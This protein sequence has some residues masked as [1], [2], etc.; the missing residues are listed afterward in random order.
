MPMENEGGAPGSPRG[1]DRGLP[2]PRSP[3]P[4]LWLHAALFG[5]C[6]LHRCFFAFSSSNPSNS[7]DVS[8]CRS[9]NSRADVDAKTQRMLHLMQGDGETFA[10][11]AEMYYTRRPELT[12]TLK[13]WH[14]SYSS[15]ARRHDKLRS[16]YVQVVTSSRSESSSSSPSNRAE[17]AESELSRCPGRA[18]NSLG[19]AIQTV[20]AESYPEDQDPMVETVE[21]DLRTCVTNGSP[22]TT[23]LKVARERKEK[24]EIEETRAIRKEALEGLMTAYEWM[25][26]ELIRRNEEKREKI[27]ELSSQINLLM[28][29]N[30]ELKNRSPECDVGAEQKR[31]PKESLLSKPKGYILKKFSGWFSSN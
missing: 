4:S 11:R 31:E 3:P 1:E 12:E 19:S 7:G 27:M 29:E 8:H 2:R 25:Q 15:L 21:L 22:G 18:E 24:E 5:L 13:D 9:A 26:A 23:C 16:H 6:H 17:H 14:K 30:A 10:E 20:Q 28:S